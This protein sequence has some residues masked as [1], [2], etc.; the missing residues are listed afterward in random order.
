MKIKT[1][2]LAIAFI[3]VSTA[4]YGFFWSSQKDLFTILSDIET[5]GADNTVVSELE[6]YIADN[7]RGDHTDEALFR[8]AGIYAG[9]KDY[10]KALKAY[11]G[12]VGN[13]PDSRYSPEALYEIGSLEYKTG[14]LDEAKAALDS[15]QFSGGASVSTKAKAAVL[16]KEISSASYGLAPRLEAPAIGL[17]LPLKGPYAQ[18]GED[19]LLGALM[20]ADAFGDKKGVVE[21]VVRNVGSDPASVEAA[22]NDL[23]DNGRVVGLVGPLLSATAFE[24]TRYAHN[25]KI[26]IITLSQKEGL[27]DG[28]Y[29]FRNFLTP[30]S[31][32]SAMAEYACKTLGRTRT[33]ILYP[34]NNYGSELAKLFENEVKALGCEVVKTASYPKSTNDFTDH[35]K[36]LFGIQVKERMEGRRKI[37]EYTSTVEIDS[38]FIPDSSD[39][40]GLIAPYLDFYNIKGVQLL[41]SNAWNS[42][43]LVELAGKNVEGAVFVDGFFIGSKRPETGEFVAR[44][45]STFGRE[46]GLIEAQAYDAAYALIAAGKSGSAG[47]DRDAVKTALKSLKGL[48]GATGPL[49]FSERGEAVKKL[50]ILT[51]KNGRIAEA[52]VQ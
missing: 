19:A 16:L 33:A 10:G 21:V 43:K 24:A 51:V 41:G 1:L 35:M 38:L 26:P 12:I 31:Q 37:K 27:T 39:S 28:E 36:R 3:F 30:A 2:V 44:F 20:A 6:G 22:I 45:N 17:L 46:P 13:F 23:A 34:Q 14:H 48:N 52:V 49:A 25:R 18:F 40:V 47:F 15:V 4:S 7:P 5:K 11:S 50:F 9:K 29:V 32:A 8:L 42:K